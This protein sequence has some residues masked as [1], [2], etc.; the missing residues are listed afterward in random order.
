VPTRPAPRRFPPVPT[1]PPRVPAL[2]WA[3]PAVPA[4][5]EPPR[6]VVVV[7]AGL[8]G[9]QTV[10][11]LRQHGFDGQLT[12]LG[13]EG[14]PP[15]DRPP[16]SKELLSRRDPVW[17]AEDLGV[18]VSRLAD[19]VRLGDPAVGLDPSP[20]GV[21]MRTDSGADVRTDAVV[22]A[23]GST[24]VVPRGWEPAWTLHTAAD[25]ARL[26]EALAPGVRLVIAGAGWI[27]AE[28]AGVAASAGAQV[29]VVEAAPVPLARQLGPTVGK[30]LDRWY[31][32][33]GV[34][35]LTGSP[36]A[37]V[38]ASDGAGPSGPDRDG[39]GSLR[40]GGATAVGCVVELADGTRLEA[41]V[42]LAAVGARPASAWLAGRLPLD[43]TGRLRVDRAG[44]L[45]RHASP[46]DPAGYLSAPTLARLWAVGDVAVREHPVFGP[47]PGGHWS[48]ALHDPEITVRAMLGVDAAP[49]DPE[50]VRA[51]LGLEPIPRHAPYVFSRQLGHDLA[52]L[53]LPT[54]T[55]E[56]LLRGDPEGGGSW[57]ALYVERALDRHPRT[58]PDGHPIATIRAVLL[59]DAPRE[60]GAVRRLMNGSEPL[61]LDLVKA[62]DPGTRLRDAVV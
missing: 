20:A 31:E 59:V 1:P 62:L 11:A 38:H 43:A 29:T 26:R 13:A 21:R 6:S 41:D 8:A 46:T 15:Y 42:V 16:L 34:R 52:L 4:T 5:P 45:A 44:R 24:P 49:S 28:L 32:A 40:K 17:L 3:S 50:E 18:D 22:L 47:V 56:V 7:G 30:H 12:L 9:A 10:A 33:A 25:A 55:D 39:D 37:A 54:P 2:V 14:V 48:A 58:T 61:R 53:G 36:V 23:M 51:R 60:V 57:A 19:E 35:L 27:G